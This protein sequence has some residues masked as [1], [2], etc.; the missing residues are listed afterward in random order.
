MN[1][2][3]APVWLGLWETPSECRKLHPAQPAKREHPNTYTSNICQLPHL[4]RC[5]RRHTRPQE[6]LRLP[7]SHQT[8]LLLP[9]PN[10]S[11]AVTLLMPIFKSKF[12]VFCKS[13]PTQPLGHWVSLVSFYLMCH[14]WMFQVLCPWAHFPTNLVGFVPW[15]WLAQWFLHCSRTNYACTYKEYYLFSRSIR[16]WI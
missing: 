4:T 10:D 1:S 15:L 5:V 16:S 13:M 8:A 7:I 14:W 11:Q 6:V 2:A 9:L 12:Q 3:F